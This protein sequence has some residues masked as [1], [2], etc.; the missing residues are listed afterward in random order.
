MIKLIET[1]DNI[2]IPGAVNDYGVMSG[3]DLTLLTARGWTVVQTYGNPVTAPGEG[4]HGTQALSFPGPIN[5]QSG[6]I[7]PSLTRNADRLILGMAVRMQYPRIRY[8]YYHPSISGFNIYF[9]YGSQVNLTVSL[10]CSANADYVVVTMATGTSGYPAIVV[11]SPNIPMLDKHNGYNFIEVMV[12]VANYKGGG[13]AKVAVNGDTYID[14][15]NI[16]T[17]AYNDFGDNPSDPRSKLNNV[18]IM[19]PT[20][21]STD[22]IAPTDRAYFDTIYLCDDDGGYQ[23]DFLGPIFSKTYYPLAAGAKSN[24]SPYVNGVVQEDGMHYARVDDDP[25]VPGLEV[26]YLEGSQDLVDEM[27]VFTPDTIPTGCEAI[28]VGQQTMFRNVAS[29]GN[30]APGTMVPIYQIAGN[31]LIVTNSLAKKNAGWLYSFLD[32]YYP[33]VPGLA[34]PWTEY[35]LEQSQFGFLLRE[36]AWTGIHREDIG[37]SDEVTLWMAT[38]KLN[39]EGEDTATTWIE[40]GQGLTPDYSEGASIDIDQH[41][42]GVSSLKMVA[43]TSPITGVTYAVPDIA[44]DFTLTCRFRF[45]AV[46]E[47]FGILIGD[48]TDDIGRFLDFAVINQDG[49]LYYWIGAGDSTGEDIGTPCEDECLLAA[50]TWHKAETLL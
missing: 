2:Q 38:F 30:P 6:L 17:A 10:T 42:T 25:V 26:E 36:P 21:S 43:C 12:D 40:D 19:L 44:A 37:I 14:I 34:I 50:D 13:L 41:Y 39:F 8:G 49:T 47:W 3:T 15:M 1:F 11:P 27:F 24:W 29:P 23:N 18:A 9:R 4:R 45:H 31:D 35:L 32:I 20:A 48:G 28:A 33:L 16:N 5:W 22:Y 7:T 46:D